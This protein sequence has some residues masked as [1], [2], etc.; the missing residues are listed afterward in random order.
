MGYYNN[1]PCFFQFPSMNSV[2]AWPAISNFV[3]KLIFVVQTASVYSLHS[4]YKNA[5]YNQT[6]SKKERDVK[7]PK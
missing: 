7:Q 5:I 6:N 4:P 3:E 2:W 1:N